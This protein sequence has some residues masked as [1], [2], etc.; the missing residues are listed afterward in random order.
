[1]Y[2]KILGGAMLVTVVSELNK[3]HEENIPHVP[4]S[5]IES[6]IPNRLQTGLSVY[7]INYSQQMAKGRGGVLPN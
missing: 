6:I 1:M 5:E 2:E 4:H 3:K 7:N